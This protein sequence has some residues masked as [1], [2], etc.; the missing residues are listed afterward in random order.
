MRNALVW[1]IRGTELDK[2]EMSLDYYT[3]RL[4]IKARPDYC[5][6]HGR[7]AVRWYVNL[8]QRI[9]GLHP[10]TSALSFLENL[11]KAFDFHSSELQEMP[12]S[13]K[14]IHLFSLSPSCWEEIMVIKAL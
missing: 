13:D 5:P 1:G 9:G 8:T 14:N 3:R 12:L 11:S 2:R 6:P 4:E 7:C 10:A